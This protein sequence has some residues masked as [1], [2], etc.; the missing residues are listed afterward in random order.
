M[1]VHLKSGQNS[2]VPAFVHLASHNQNRGTMDISVGG[3]ASES[4]LDSRDVTIGRAEVSG[5]VDKLDDH[6]TCRATGQPKEED[7]TPHRPLI[8]RAVRPT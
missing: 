6:A 4:I 2:D 8:D 1:N 3:C 5:L 7:R